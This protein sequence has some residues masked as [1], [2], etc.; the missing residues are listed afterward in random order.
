MVG[1]ACVGTPADDLLAADALAAAEPNS[2][3]ND[4]KADSSLATARLDRATAAE[5]ATTFEAQM[6]PQLKA[7]FDA[8]QT[9]YA[10]YAID[11]DMNGASLLGLTRCPNAVHVR[12]AIDGV[13]DM[14]G[15][16]RAT[17]AEISA[18]LGRWALPQLKAACVGPYSSG[19]YV[20]VDRVTPMFYDAVFFTQ[21]RNLLQREKHPN[22]MNLH[23]LRISW[24][25]TALPQLAHE[26]L[27]PVQLTTAQV[28]GNPTALF[29]VLRQQFPLT[30][31]ALT[32]TGPDAAANFWVSIDGS[33]SAAANRLTQAL[34]QPSIK[35]T[36]YFSGSSNAGPWQDVLLVIDEHN[37][38]WGF[39]AQ[40]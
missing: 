20:N 13:L 34:R 33:A 22:G 38:A 28:S 8:Y 5:V 18:Q 25:A 7:C 21:A 12:F 40:K 16:N 4:G 31:T 30:H 2:N 27:P 29:R 36:F 24:L 15:R 1:S 14:M 6:A 35:Q 9:I 3:T 32:D 26:N 39:K 23:D 11:I 37:Q 17:V 10:P 19:G